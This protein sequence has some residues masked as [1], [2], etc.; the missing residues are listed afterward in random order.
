MCVSGLFLEHQEMYGMTDTVLLPA[1]RHVPWSKAVADAVTDVE[2]EGTEA[3][4]LHVFDAA[5]EASTR[6]NL[7]DSGDLSLDDLASRKSG[8]VAAVDVLTDA[9]VDATPKGARESDSKARNILDV[10]I[11]ADADR[12]YLY[13]RR[14]SPTGKAVFGSVVQEI[15]LDA[16]VPVTIVPPTRGV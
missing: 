8:V 11:D 4:V 3:L 10:G 14:R 2:D 15:V 9:G 5:E 16:H 12:L 1:K 13:G 7:D 6:E